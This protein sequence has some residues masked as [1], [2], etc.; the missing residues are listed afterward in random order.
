MKTRFVS[1]LFL[2][3]VGW[4][5]ATPQTINLSDNSSGKQFD[6]I[7]A[8][9][10]GGATS[11]LLKDYPEPQR[12][13]IMDMV[14]RPMFGASVSAILVEV[15][16][17]GNSTQGSMPS[18]SHYR[19]DA[20][21]LRG[22]M[23]WVMQEARRRNSALSLDATSWSAPAWVGNFWSDDMVDYYID[24]MKGLRQVHGLEL[25]ALGC[26]NE[27][28]WSADFAKHLRKAMNERG[29]RDVKLHGF[30]NWGNQK[31]DFL[32]RMQ[33]D[34]ELADALDAV[35]AHTFSEI[36]LT[37]EQRKMAEDMGKPI[38][39][40]EDH[41]YLPGF[42]CLISIVK[43][44]NANYIVSGATKVINWY[45]IGATYPLEPYSK[46]PPMLLAQEPWSGHYIVREALWGY[47]HYGQFTRVGWR[48]VDEGCLL[49]PQGG[50]MVT[51]RDPQTG[52]Y[53]IVAET[54]GAKKAQT[55]KV[56]VA[57]GLSKGKLCVW[58]SDA[59]QQFVRLKDITP[60]G[61]KFSITLKPDAVYSFST[62]T[63]QQKGSFVD[64][65]AS[66][67]FP[68]PY[69]DDF[70]Q[71]SNP[72]EWGYLPHYLADLIG[73]FELR[74]S[75]ARKGMSIQQTVGAHTLSWAPEWHHYT[76]L[77]DA[78][79]KD[80][81]ISADVYLNPGDEAGVMGRLC[82]VGSGYGI[83]AK[84][85][86][87]KLD[88]IGHCTLILTRGK[89]NQKELIGDKEQQALILARKDV[90]IGGEYTLS[91]ADVK[92]ISSCQW[93][94]LKLR[95]DEDQITGYIDDVEVIR[96]T[97][98]HYG[99]G[100]AGLI[101]PLHE[102]RVSTPYFDN[103]CITPIGR[104]QATS[105][106]IPAVQP[107]Y[108]R[109][110]PAAGRETLLQRLKSLSDRG[111]MFGHQDAPFYG[112]DWQWDRGRSDVLAVCGDYPAVMGFELGG[113][114]MGDEKNLDSVPFNRIREELLAHVRRG[115]IATIS[116]HSRNPLTGG[117]AWDNK[118][119]EV[120]RSILPEGS[121]YQ[122]FQLWMLRL[123]SFLQSL[124]DEHGR[125]VPFIFRPWHENSGGWFWWGKGLCSSEEYKALWNCL[126]DRLLADG[127]TNIVWSWSPNFGYPSDIFDTYP[128]DER[129]DII[130]LDAYQHRGGEKDFISTLNKDLT[131]LCNYAKKAN[132]LV[133][134]TECGY[135][136][137]P[138]ST[139]WTRV[140][141]PQIQKYP[142]CYFLVW[143]NADNRQYFAPA[144]T[145]HDA[146]DFR[147]MV[148]DSKILML[149]DIENR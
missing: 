146:P 108:P 147:R 85:Y 130:G 115:G 21:F 29:F 62:T 9:N 78:G 46:E 75:P 127:L 111:I 6:G 120:V 102:R 112:L 16:G 107:L 53:S 114:E 148:G 98:D 69:K 43:C 95:F 56:R 131:Q 13:Q 23:W 121:Q 87:L 8:V 60:K 25:D 105:T 64:I 44:F 91:E 125:P 1:S 36:Q 54:K 17:D 76:I 3:F 22:Y 35:C 33:E 77:G 70:E 49:L 47:A 92:G 4:S 97:S 79:W 24:W 81:E 39:N 73:C 61:G 123:S 139:W 19:G 110:T 124:C 122:K 90:E 141:K 42:D 38:W 94:N 116:W 68:I 27:K 26:H 11:V 52:D 65:P 86:Y 93:H 28:G 129:V 18:H 40:S 57:D 82:D 135:Q 119:K 67:P 104:T 41:V 137:L 103:V 59:K 132:R 144:P 145:T 133:A 50:S 89:R 30:G 134:L 143:R 58:Y 37:P 113:I 126:Q 32:K 140:L 63:G 149:K 117:T 5:S 66:K 80:Y 96:A 20:N 55:I 2:L 99:Q 142:L 10:G 14:Y 34:P 12:S 74:P 45:D 106:T 84:G 15:P 71:Y 7:G 101:A 109:Q 138:D 72:E 100:M 48:Y 51:M 118:N 136:N 88:D 83:W 31:M 128:G